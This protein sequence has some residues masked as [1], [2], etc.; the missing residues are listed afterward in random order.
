MFCSMNLNFFERP[1]KRK[2]F[3]IGKEGSIEACF[4]SQKVYVFK[5]N[6]KIVKNFKFKKN[7]IFIEEL[8]FFISK[9]NQKQKYQIP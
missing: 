3:L 5:N 2:F 6:K 4:N 1:K 7:D 8:K 9:L